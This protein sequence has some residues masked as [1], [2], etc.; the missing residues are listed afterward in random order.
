MSTRVV[1][2]YFGR[3]QNFEWL[4]GCEIGCILRMKLRAI[5]AANVKA[6][7]KAMNLSQEEVALRA[8]VSRSF[9]YEIERAGYSARLDVVERIAKVLRAEAWELLK[10]SK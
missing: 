9:M 5:F 10:P 7:R 1:V 3:I 8:D 6:R 2:R 4:S